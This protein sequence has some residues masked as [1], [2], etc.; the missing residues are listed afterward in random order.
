MALTLHR[1]ARLCALLTLGL[2]A[3]ASSATT[4]TVTTLD[5]NTNTDGQVSLREAVMASTTNAAV[6]DAPAGD[7]SG[8]VINFAIPGTIL[9]TQGQLMIGDDLVV[10][11]M[12]I[13]IDA[14]SASRI[15]MVSTSEAVALNDLTL[16]GGGSVAQGGAVY[17]V[18]ELTISGGS[19][20]DN[21]TSGSAATD[22]GGGVYNDGGDLT[23]DGVSIA[24]NEAAGGSSSGGGVFH[25]GGTTTIT[26]GSFVGN[27]AP[28]AGGGI[29]AAT[30]GTITIDGTDFTG[31]STGTAPGNGGA[32][33]V[34][35]G[36][37]DVTG[38]DVTNNSAASEGGGFWNNAGWTMTVDGTSFSGNNAQGDAADNGGGALFNN[39]GTLMVMN[40]SITGN[41]ANGM[42]GSGGGAF[43]ANGIFI[44]EST[45]F[46]GNTSNRAGGGIENTGSL[47]D[48]DFPD[49]DTPRTELRD[50]TITGNNAGT[51]PGNG[52][53]VHNG[54]G[55]FVQFFTGMVMNNTAVEGGGL[56]S[57]GTML[58]GDINLVSTASSKRGSFV[59]LWN[60]SALAQ[61]SSATKGPGS[62]FDV[63]ISGNEATGDDAA[64]GGGGIYNE[65]GDFGLFN[66]QI[67]SNDASGTSGSGGGAF[68]NSGALGMISVEISGNTANRAGGGIEDVGGTAE[69]DTEG[70]L[71]TD[72]TITGNDAGMNPGNGGGIHSG[73]GYVQMRS[74][75]VSGNTAV[76]GGG[77][78]TSG[79][80]IVG[81]DEIIRMDETPSGGTPVG[82]VNVMNNTATGDEAA[83]GGGGLYNQNGDL[84][85]LGTVVAMN[86]ATGTSGSGGGLLNNNGTLTVSNSVFMNN[87]ANRAGGG[88][89]DANV[90]SEA[91]QDDVS[92]DDTV[93]M[94]NDAGANPGNGGGLHIGGPGSV[95]V[96]M[97]TFT[98]NTAVEGAGLWN[99]GAG[100]LTVM[101]TSV[102]DGTATRGGGLYQSGTASTGVGGTLELVQSLV[103][104]NT[105]NGGGG[106]VEVVAG[107]VSMVNSTLSG[108]TA[109]RGGG[110]RQLSGTVNLN[111]VTIA[112]NEGTRRAGGIRARGG[113][114]NLRNTIIAENTSPQGPSC[115]GTITSLDFNLIEDR[116]GCNI[117]GDLSNS[118]TNVAAMLEDLADNGGPTM[119]HALE[120]GSPA[121]DA[122]QTDEDEDQRGFARDNGQ[123]DM[124]AFELGGSPPAI[125]LASDDQAPAEVVETETEETTTTK[126]ETTMD[127]P[128]RL[129][130]VAPNPLRTG[131]S[132]TVSFAVREAEAVEVAL[133]D[134]AGRRVATLYSGTPAASQPTAAALETGS[135]AAGV[136]VV[137]L[138][139]ETVSATRMVT[140]VR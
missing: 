44:V 137:R 105:A 117:N 81:G 123:D 116:T 35:A 58:V 29:E 118:Q 50:V 96:T 112:Q 108:N 15:F 120:S 13:T 57:A 90:R 38:G 61:Q 95:M 129:D 140:I 97:S 132:G 86:Q 111:S 11:G 91:G 12:G 34:T 45:T 25:N 72:V 37:V 65:G 14:Q 110:F 83:D 22:G 8:D 30:G 109:I 26:G 9:L 59:E 134:V 67:S 39:G 64:D 113:T 73:G 68:N 98:D 16:T 76:E 107:T 114:T 60:S 36:D 49:S 19:I 85:L 87:S 7:A 3:S 28:R 74:G 20:S 10:N 136:Y 24:D 42:A 56:W 100:T 54:G 23:L 101:T 77:L 89:E 84:T 52:G 5:D 92:I 121:I 32:I 51:S 133:Y 94:G 70:T 46:D 69:D 40:A 53:G 99:S 79:E 41:T 125:L 31:N 2:F 103:A 1:A 93:F 138:M 104:N 102:M 127:E 128:V 6:G 80:M 139:G 135:L 4:Y 71:L 115:S 130:A 119:T 48:G 43:N 78:W 82:A 33:H 75:E 17:S 131:V 106:G 88:I 126:G 55:G 63:V 62:G 21:V 124:G 47:M 27:F 66:T 122:G 18:A